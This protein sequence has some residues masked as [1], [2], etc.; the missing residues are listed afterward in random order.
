MVT[1]GPS[2][3]VVPS[4]VLAKPVGPR[5]NLRC[6]YCFY[7]PERRGFASGTGDLRLMSETTLHRLTAEVLRLSVPRPSLCWQGGEPTLAGLA[8]Y[9]RALALQ[10]ELGRDRAISNSLQTNGLL[11]D[12]QWTAFLRREGFLVGLSLDGPRDLH[13]AQRRDASGAGSWQRV[14]D[15]ARRLQDSEVP[16]N[17]LCCLTSA[18]AARAEELYAFFTEEGFAHVQFIPLLEAMQ[19]DSGEPAAF[20]LTPEAYGD[21]LC[22]LWNLWLGALESGHSMG[23][24]FFES[25]CHRALGLPPTLCEMYPGCGA[26]A[27]V[28]RDGGIYP[29]DFFV[30]SHWRLGSLNQGLPEVLTS[31]KARHFNEIRLLLQPECRR[32]PW[33]AF[34]H[35]GCLKYRRLGLRLLPRTFFCEAYKT[36]FAHA[37]S[38]LTRVGACLLRSDHALSSPNPTEVLT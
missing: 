26:Y 22:R 4:A 23:V 34:C 3:S 7:Q 12:R 14:M 16:V 6:G 8:F 29:C 21:M 30:S 18:S 19:P 32:C 10:R 28:E 35:G 31:P 2:L 38:D 36:F 27:V 13:D 37:H 17:A 24:R 11:L 20:S 15:A 1:E 9:E 25:F 33:L 5:C